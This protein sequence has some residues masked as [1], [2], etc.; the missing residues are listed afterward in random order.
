[1]KNM[2]LLLRNFILIIT[3]LLLVTGVAV[4]C[5]GPFSLKGS[6]QGTA[7][8]GTLTLANIDPITLDPA[9]SQDM[10]SHA[11]IVQ[12]FSGLV[13]LDEKLKVAPDIASSWDVGADGRVYTFHIRP[14]A[15]FQNGRQITAED[16]KYSWER[17]ASPATRSPTASAFLGDIS[18][19]DEVLGGKA[20]EIRGLT[21]V[22]SNT[23]RVE[24]KEPRTSFLSRITYPVAFAVD[25]DDVKR[26]G[27][28]WRKPNGSGPF[29]LEQ[30]ETSNVLVLAA[31]EQYYGGKPLLKKVVYRLYS[32]VPLSLYEQNQIDV[33]HVSIANVDRVRDESN[34]L[35]NELGVYPQL[36]LEYV[37]F[38]VAMPPFDDPGVR[39]AFVRAIDREKIVRLTLRDTAN[40]AKG[41]IPSGMPGYNPGLEG[42]TY[43]AQEARA[44]LAQS[45]YRGPSDLPPITLTTSGKGG[46]IA[47][48]LSAIVLQWKQNLGV[49]VTVRVLGPEIFF[50]RA[51]EVV[52]NIYDY[53]WVADYPDPENFLDMLFHAD[54]LNN[55]GGYNNPEVDSLIDRARVERDEN[56]RIELLRSAE[57]IVVEDA[58]LLPLWFG[59]D[60][61]LKKQY[62]QNYKY[63][64]VGFAMLSKVYLG[65]SPT[66]PPSLPPLII[67]EV[68]L[69]QQPVMTPA[70][71]PVIT[72]VPSLK[73]EPGITVSPSFPPVSTPVPTPVSSSKEGVG[74]VTMVMLIIAGLFAG[75]AMT[76]L[77]T[78]IKKPPLPPLS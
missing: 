12:I 77:F 73:P 35:H 64:P 22:D 54:R 1:M 10:T 4:T 40:S 3:V 74:I 57:K 31:N 71:V 78:R 65:V 43:N 7:S 6:A 67:P 46:V 5:S 8:E 27:D 63:L 25:R 9:V 17:A 53:G 32:G 11:Y 70:P 60:F 19:M 18:G 56:K 55:V 66:P 42:L 58:A 62:V 34:P 75:G 39:K 33:T 37:A 69:P 30:W 29:K 72:P 44:L 14:D 15:K 49:D 26:G 48:Y 20:R 24:L 23:L 52:D 61:I 45:K 51:K 59:R 47:D 16:I 36:S 68:T 2:P 21:V 41:I 13:T 50:Y 38:N 76:Y 28:W